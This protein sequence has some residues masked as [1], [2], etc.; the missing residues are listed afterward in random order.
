MWRWW[1]RKWLWRRRGEVRKA[2][3]LKPRQ[4]NWR[5]SQKIQS[6]GWLK[7]HGPLHP[8]E[9]ACFSHTRFWLISIFWDRREV[10]EFWPHLCKSPKAWEKQSFTCRNHQGEKPWSRGAPSSLLPA[11]SLRQPHGFW[12][13]HAPEGKGN[14]WDESTE[15][16]QSVYVPTGI[17]HEEKGNKV[18][19]ISFYF[20]KETR[21]ILNGWQ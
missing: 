1:W 6:S 5:E 12:G 16:W 15:R 18:W 7:S 9:D 20:S 14:S 10:E 4:E 17:P 13:G 19:L 21:N 3:K 2:C 8:P 11:T